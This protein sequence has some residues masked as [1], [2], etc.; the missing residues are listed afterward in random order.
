MAVVV[1]ITGDRHWSDYRLIFN[2]LQSWH[3]RVG[4]SLVVHGACRGADNLGAQAACAMG[5]A[6]DPNPA[7]WDQYGLKAGPIRNG[8]MLIHHPEIELCLGFHDHIESS[9]GTVDMLRKAN[10]RG[11]LCSLEGHW[12][13]I[14][15]Y[16]PPPHRSGNKS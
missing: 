6:D 9:R 10:N 15:P 7:D 14:T 3:Q 12:G 1:L 2:S 11:I 13:V 4:I 16:L 5:I 8:Q